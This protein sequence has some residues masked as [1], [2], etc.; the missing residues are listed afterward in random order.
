MRYEISKNEVIFADYGMIVPCKMYLS[1]NKSI[2]GY[3]V[4]PFIKLSGKYNIFNTF[5]ISDDALIVFDKHDRNDLPYIILYSLHNWMSSSDMVNK[6]I[7]SPW[8]SKLKSINNDIFAELLPYFN[9][10]PS[11][12]EYDE[13]N[14][15][16]GYLLS[17]VLNVILKY[18]ML[19][20]LFIIYSNLLLN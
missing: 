12:N 19:L 7:K 13:L 6:M 14:E 9:R 16:E 2:D 18:Y 17:L 10:V 15:F 1:K 5:Y 20:I 8:G 11:Y 3:M 4:K